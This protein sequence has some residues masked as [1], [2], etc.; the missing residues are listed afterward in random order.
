MLRRPGR[1]LPRTKT[2]EVID[3]DHVVAI[4][5]EQPS[6]RRESND[7]CE[8]PD[9]MLLSMVVSGDQRATR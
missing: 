7:C 5:A 2:G 9:P 4:V 6:G 8:Q 1:W 3:S